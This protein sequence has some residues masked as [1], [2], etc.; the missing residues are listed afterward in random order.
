M[1]PK[2]LA[3][4]SP[5]TEEEQKILSGGTVEK[6]RYSNAPDFKIQSGKMIGDKLVSI[7]CH[8][9]FTAFPSH[10]HDY[11]EMIYMCAGQT[12]HRLNGCQ[13]VTLRQGEILLLN[14]Y[15][16]HAI[17]PAGREDIA[18]NFFMRP[19]FFDTAFDMLEGESPLRAFLTHDLKSRQSQAEYMVFHVS[20]VPPV[21]NLIE[22]LIWSVLEGRRE[23]DL[24]R[25]T[26]ALL[27]LN[28]LEHADQMIEQ[29]GQS[30]E[31]TMIL[32][33][34]SYIEK[35]YRTASLSHIAGQLRQPVP[36]LSRLIKEKTGRTFKEM[37]MEQRM[38]RAEYLLRHSELSVSDV[39]EAVGYSN[40]SYFYR[41]F[42][43]EHGA[44]PA[45]WRRESPATKDG[46]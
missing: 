45:G 5:I 31:N 16:T 15:A 13:D 34:L 24:D 19:A 36:R 40:T 46:F 33:V 20:D 29:D 44:S 21:Q 2:L 39:I 30:Y 3:L 23:S 9:R 26:L 38:R 32:S 28:I 6:E 25:L 41:A 37:L 1:N 10:S 27:F 7:R 14:Q 11:I 22:N 35:Y 42:R 17:E 43:A 8:T 18:V 12:R 4:L